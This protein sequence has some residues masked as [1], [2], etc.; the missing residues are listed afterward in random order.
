MAGELP[1]AAAGLR[2]GRRLGVAL[3]R[4]TLIVIR[5]FAPWAWVALAIVWFGAVL[6]ALTAVTRG[7]LG[8]SGR[9]V[10]AATLVVASIIALMTVRRWITAVPGFFSGCVFAGLVSYSGSGVSLGQAAILLASLIA[11]GFFARELST[12]SLTNRDRTALTAGLMSFFIAFIAE[13]WMPVWA[14][15]MVVFFG[16]PWLQWKRREAR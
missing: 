9:S 16:V 13:E 8:W 2:Y 3:A 6:I 10:G 7:E 5:S 14:C 15:G 1:K 11:C 4:S 12:R